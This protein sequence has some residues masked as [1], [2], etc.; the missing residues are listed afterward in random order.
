MLNSGQ[1]PGDA[2]YYDVS[3]SGL[4]TAVL[5]AVRDAERRGALD[6]ERPHLARAFQDALVETLAAK[7]VRAA[8][9]FHRQR[10]VLG[11][12][13]ACNAA[14][15]RAVTERAHA[16][17][18]RDVSVFA[19]A[20]RLATDNAAMIACAALFHLARGERSALSLNAYA[21]LPLPCTP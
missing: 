13:V 11:G 14:L 17:I 15:V 20:P 7:T 3:F 21:A 8:T 9:A 19:P 5:H 2:D 18:G 1:Q 4:K 16:Q 12:G 6:K 10:V